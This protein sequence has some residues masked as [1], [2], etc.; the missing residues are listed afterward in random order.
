MDIYVI[1]E[2][3]EKIGYLTILGKTGLLIVGQDRM[4]GHLGY[5]QTSLK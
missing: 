2:K 1:K 4:I 3:L 5:D